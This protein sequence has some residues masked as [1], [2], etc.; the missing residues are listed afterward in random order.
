MSSRNMMEVCRP[1]YG[2]RDQDQSND[3][4]VGGYVPDNY[5]SGR[6]ARA[7]AKRTYVNSICA[8]AINHHAG[9]PFLGFEL[10]CMLMLDQIT[11]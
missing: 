6:A 7:W 1:G 3:M 10:I 5:V 11:L 9:K 8:C 4:N 2:Y